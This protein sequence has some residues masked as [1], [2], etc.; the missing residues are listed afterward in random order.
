MTDRQHLLKSGCTKIARPNGSSALA[1]LAANTKTTDK[2]VSA[3]T[4]RVPRATV[5]QRPSGDLAHSAAS[6]GP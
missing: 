3:P 5:V 2:K 6:L 1:T 4:S